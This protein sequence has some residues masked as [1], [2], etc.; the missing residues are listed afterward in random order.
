MIVEQSRNIVKEVGKVLVGKDEIISKALMAI[1]SGG[2]I[3]LE[4]C[5]G[6]GK[7]TLAIGISKAL[8]L[9]TKRIQFT[10]DTMPSDIMGFTV[11]N[12]ETHEFEYKPGAAFTNLLLGDEINRTSPKTQSALLEVMAEGSATVDGV[13]HQLPKPF[14]CIATQN[15][16]GSAGT[17]PLPQSQLDRFAVR[18]SIGYPD[19]ENQARILETRGASAPFETIN[20][21]MNEDELLAT[22]NFIDSITMSRS[23]IEYIVKLCEGTRSHRLVDLGVSP[24]GMLSMSR[25]ARACAIVMDR[26]FVVPED[27]QRVFVDSCA[28]RLVLS[29]QARVEAMTDIDVCK[30]VLAS[31]EP[32][33]LGA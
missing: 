18:L 32:P 15:P 31:V 21:V 24:R 9:S 27:V 17:Q 14:V 25:M 7:T 26:D 12:N 3:L 11:Y 33:A 22:Q 13:T 20:Q 28:H 8:G 10:P 2:H 6:V 16:M 29:P 1:Y 30:E 5:P 23:I 19:F 4:D